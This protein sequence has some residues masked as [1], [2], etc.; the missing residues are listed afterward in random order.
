MGRNCDSY[1]CDLSDKKQV[2]EIVP[3]ICGRDGKNV[4]ILV[5]CGG[6]QHRSAAVDFAEERWDEVGF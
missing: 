1:A 4:D 6:M 3:S 5:N 2:R